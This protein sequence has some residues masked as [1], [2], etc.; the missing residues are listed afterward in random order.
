MELKSNSV[1]WLS[2]KKHANKN[3]VINQHFI[4]EYLSYQ[5]TLRIYICYDSANKIITIMLPFPYN[6]NF[7]SVCLIL[8]KEY[9]SYNSN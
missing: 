9:Q 6:C 3:S 7:A 5:N 1:L 2:D 4:P 8:F